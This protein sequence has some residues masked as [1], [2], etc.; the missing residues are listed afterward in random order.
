MPAM[1]VNEQLVVHVEDT[2]EEASKRKFTHMF[3]GMLEAGK[4][5]EDLFAC[6]CVY[7]LEQLRK[8]R[9]RGPHVPLAPVIRVVDRVEPI[10]YPREL[11]HALAVPL[12]LRM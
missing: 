6:L 3:H 8:L 7:V 2:Q 1:A 4:P 5:A 11:P 9:E 10:Q 12:F